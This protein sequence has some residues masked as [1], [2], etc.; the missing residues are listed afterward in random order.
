MV[1]L[2]SGG[3]KQGAAKN[4]E[5]GE[6][7]M[8]QRDFDVCVCG[9]GIA[10]IAAALASAR[11]GAKT[12]LLEK[13]YALGGLAT[14][15]LIVIYLAL[16]DGDGTLMSTGI[17]EELLKLSYKYA[18][19]TR[20]PD[21][22]RHDAPEEARAGKRYETEYSPAAMILACEELLLGEGVTIFYDARILGAEASEGRVRAVTVATKTGTTE[23]RA[24]AFVDCTGDADVCYFAGEPTVDDPKN[25]RTGWHYTYDGSK[26]KLR[27]LT[28]PLWGKLPETSRYYSGT[29]LEDISANVIDMRKFVLQHLEKVRET[30]PDAYPF[31]IPSYHGLR[32]TRRLKAP[33]VEFSEKEHERVWFENAIGMIGNWK[34]LHMRYSLPFTMIHASVNDN[35]YA[36]GRC[37]AA[38]KSGEQSGWDLTRVIP[39]CAVTGQAAGTAAAMQAASGSVPEIGAL[40]DRL[41]ADGVRLDPS[42]FTRTLK[43]E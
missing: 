27:G 34:R 21:E 8:E 7:G 10:G 42:L 22:W 28:D 32:M 26:L 11:S 13:E 33:G 41:R 20:L 3:A 31:L 17:P 24:K 19:V 40:Q 2:A 25:V 1:A 37:A 43:G 16:D 35:L 23:F 4:G 9:G 5:S 38:E 30:E 6:D 15:G 18:P 14:L 36:A 29:T 39:S 12:V